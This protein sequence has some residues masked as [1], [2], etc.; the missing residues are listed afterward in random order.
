MNTIEKTTLSLEELINLIN[1]HP[2]VI[3]SEIWT[4]DNL[5]SR[6]EDEI[7]NT[8]SPKILSGLSL[9]EQVQPITDRIWIENKGQLS[10]NIPN[11]YHDAWMDIV[12][13]WLNQHHQEFNLKKYEE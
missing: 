5:M 4:K 2:D 10:R 11:E 13:D 7:E 9:D 8:Y 3:S 1:N 6:V 12:F